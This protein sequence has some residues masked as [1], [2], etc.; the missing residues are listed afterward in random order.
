MLVLLLTLVVAI[1]TAVAGHVVHAPSA[2]VT[3]L[4]PGGGEEVERYRRAAQP[5]EDQ[6]GIDVAI[7]GST[8]FENEIRDRVENGN[9]PDVALFPQPGLLQAFVEGGHTQDLN[10]WFDQAYLT[11]RYDQMWLDLGTMEG[12]LAGVFYLASLK[13]L[14]WYPISDFV[15]AGYEVPTTW[16][17]LMALSDQMVTNGRTPWCVGIESGAAS[18]WVATDWVE[19]VMLRTTSAQNYERWYSGD[20]KFIYPE[21]RDSVVTMGDIWFKE[22]YVVGGRQDIVE[23]FFGD[24]ILPMFHDPPECWLHRQSMLVPN[25]L[26]PGVEIGEDVSYFYLPSIDPAQGR[27]V[28]G[29]GQMTAAFADRP[30]VREFVGYLTTGASTK[31][32]IESGAS[33]S[34]HND[35]DPAWYPDFALGYLGILASATDFAFDASDQMPAAVGIGS[36]FPGMVDYVEGDDLEGI[37]RTIDASWPPVTS[38]A[39]ISDTGGSAASANG[40]VSIAFP[41]GSLSQAMTVTITT[42]NA[43]PQPTADLA[44]AG[45]AIA[46]G[47]T[48]LEGDPVQVFSRTFTL[49]LGYYD[50]DWETAPL[51]TE[52]LLSAY[53]WQGAWQDLG[54][55]AGCRQDTVANMIACPLGR[56]GQFILAGDQ[57]QIHLPLVASGLTPPAYAWG[58]QVTDRFPNCGL[59]R[60]FGFTRDAAGDLAGDVWV[61]VWAEGWDGV[62][63]KSQ[64]T[65]FG[66][67]NGLVGDEGNWDAVLDNKPRL[68]D[69][70]AC[71]VS[72]DGAT[73]CQSNPVAASTDLDCENG[74]QVVRL[75][76]WQ[77]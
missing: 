2:T 22:G 11:D 24:A 39:V 31:P 25:F 26:P 1:T 76:F 67:D 46:V 34:P 57:P 65:A 71:V 5:F 52:T 73:E 7:E 28:L 23:T 9:P 53:E 61:R 48:N 72:A 50:A 12:E 51:F 35:T 42:T 8:D 49:T 70:R 75:A 64:W 15:G 32:F 56:L 58:G 6:T 20:L 44:Y 68:V 40:L 47:A 54:T 16:T 29:G 27:P 74:V 36:F 4:V 38:S 30:E 43:A 3:V 66:E 17:E 13:S 55:Q 77:K 37:L 14:V 33:L 69:W 62:W 10:D 60:V 63:V 21:V 18:G 41:A 45:R 19:D 59:T